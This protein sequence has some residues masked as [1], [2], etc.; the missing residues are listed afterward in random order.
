MSIR[1]V[2]CRYL[3]IHLLKLSGRIL[4]FTLMLLGSIARD[5]LRL[6]AKV[7]QWQF[8]KRLPISRR[9]VSKSI[10]Q[11]SLAF[12]SLHFHFVLI[13]FDLTSYFQNLAVGI[14]QDSSFSNSQS[15]SYISEL[16]AASPYV[17]HD[18]ALSVIPQLQFAPRSLPSRVTTLLKVLVSFF[19]KETFS[20]LSLSRP[21]CV[22]VLHIIKPK[23]SNIDIANSQPTCNVMY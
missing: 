12:L 13:L 23:L 11:S 20:S 15:Q 5:F 21:L 4:Q 19:C 9:Y 16:I 14:I 6:A 17:D 2:D 8:N 1:G 18:A 22:C 10:G 7:M 3:L